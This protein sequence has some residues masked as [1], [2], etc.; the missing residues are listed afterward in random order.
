MIDHLSRSLDGDVMGDL[1]NDLNSG[2]MDDIDE[3]TESGCGRSGSN[4]TAAGHRS[5]SVKAFMPSFPDAFRITPLHTIL[6]FTST[7]ASF[8]PIDDRRVERL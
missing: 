2:A 7:R 6:P 5:T 8:T 1:D 4:A 3:A